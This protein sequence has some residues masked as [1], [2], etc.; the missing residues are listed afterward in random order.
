MCDGKICGLTYT[1]FITA[2]KK[3]LGACGYPADS[4]SGSVLILAQ[5]LFPFN[6]AFWSACLVAFFT[7]MRKSTLLPG[8][9]SKSPDRQ[10]CIRDVSVTDATAYV[11]IRHF[12]TFQFGQR[13]LRLPLP[14]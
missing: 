8:K 2:L 10:L 13:V 4:Y 1:A 14:V 7:F 11:T 5:G 12:K 3:V 6:I 9:Q